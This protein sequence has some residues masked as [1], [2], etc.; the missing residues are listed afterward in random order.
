ML[1]FGDRV[2]DGTNNFAKINLKCYTQCC[3]ETGWLYIPNHWWLLAASWVSS[4]Y[5]QFFF[6]LNVLKVQYYSAMSMIVRVHEYV[7]FLSLKMWIPVSPPPPPHTHKRNWPQNRLSNIS[8]FIYFFFQSSELEP[9]HPY[10]HSGSGGEGTLACGREWSQFQRGDKNAQHFCWFATIFY[11]IRSVSKFF[12]FVWV[13]FLIFFFCLGKNSIFVKSFNLVTRCYTLSRTQRRNTKRGELCC[14][15]F[16]YFH[17]EDWRREKR[18][19]VV[20]PVS[21]DGD[22]DGLRVL[23]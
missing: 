4:K 12:W 7:V 8:F 10:T 17:R 21:A 18:Q 3:L 1:I 5:S 23:I 2:Q 9:P 22:G 6:T 20:L 19:V 15:H 14:N 13:N 11:Y 16:S